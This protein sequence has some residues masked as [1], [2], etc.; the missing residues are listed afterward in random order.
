[1]VINKAYKLLQ[2]LTNKDQVGGYLSPSEF[3]TYAEFV[4]LDI[5]NETY[6]A[7]TKAGYE[8]DYEVMNKFSELR[9]EQILTKSNNRFVKPAD[10]MYYS[11]MRHLTMFG[12]N[13]V[14]AP[15]DLIR[16][17]EWQDRRI[18]QVDTPTVWSPCA[19]EMDTY[20]E[21]LPSG[22]VQVRLTYLKLPPKPE[23]AFTIVS[24]E[25]VFDPTNSVDFTLSE[26]SLS[27]IVFKLCSYFG[28]EIKDGEI[29]QA[30]QNE[31][32]SEK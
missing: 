1:M 24:G 8:A 3:N 2:R 7:K 6:N 25:P 29:Y 11:S 20:F 12:H 9:K 22:V 5:I 16:D 15:V 23:W 28:I 30:I 13:P 4:Q 31:K 14:D 18:S 10:Y 32:M 17:S 27:D 26:T 21:V 19:R